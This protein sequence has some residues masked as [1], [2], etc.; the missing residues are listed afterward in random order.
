MKAEKLA[1]WLQA[2]WLARAGALPPYILDKLQRRHEWAGKF[3]PFRLVIEHSALAKTKLRGEIV[4]GRASYVDF[5]APDEWLVEPNSSRREAMIATTGNAMRH[6]GITRAGIISKFDLCK[7]SYGYSRVENG[8]KLFWH[9]RWMPVRLNLFQKVQVGHE[10]RHRSM[11]SNSR[12]R[13]FISNSMRNLC[14]IG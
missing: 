13:R 6:L 4:G 3:D 7:F 2:G 9:D 1:S 12:T 8:P 11:S 14:R 10:L 5:T